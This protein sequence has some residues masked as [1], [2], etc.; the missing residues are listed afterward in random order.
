MQNETTSEPTPPDWRPHSPESQL[1]QS[2]ALQSSHEMDV[3]SIPHTQQPAHTSNVSG[4]WQSQTSGARVQS[5]RSFEGRHSGSVTIPSTSGAPSTPAYSRNSV[6]GGALRALRAR[7]E[8][9]DWLGG[10]GAA[11]DAGPDRSPAESAVLTST[12]GSPSAPSFTCIHREAERGVELQGMPSGADGSPAHSGGTGARAGGGLAGGRVAGSG[13]RAITRMRE[14]APSMHEEEPVEEVAPPPS[15][16]TIS[17]S[18][19]AAG[20]SPTQREAGIPP[21]QRDGSHVRGGGRPPVGEEVIEYGVSTRDGGGV[22]PYG[23][24]LHFDE[25]QYSSGYEEERLDYGTQY[26]VSVT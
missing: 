26:E 8:H 3:R 5:N 14:S 15:C 17:D 19:P 22:P 6:A 18:S 20:T 24:R 1:F 13:F 7:R 10:L 23:G 4:Q 11:P 25:E 16:R 9:E 21:A 2:P 12:S